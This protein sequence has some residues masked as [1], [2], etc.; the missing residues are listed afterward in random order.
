[1]SSLCCWA[2]HLTRPLVVQLE[3]Q[4]AVVKQSNRGQ[5]EVFAS[6]PFAH[7]STFGGPGGGVGPGGGAGGGVRPDPQG[8]PM[9]IVPHYM[10]EAALNEVG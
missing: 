7:A 8:R 9:Q 2:P 5:L 10:K 3:R 6:Q 1:M 4:I